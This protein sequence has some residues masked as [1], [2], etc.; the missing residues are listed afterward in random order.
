[1]FDG[2][3]KQQKVD[4][5]ANYLSYT[6]DTEPPVIYHRWCWLTSLG[7]CIGRKAYIDMGAIGRVFPNLYVQLLGAPAARKSTS[8]KMIKRLLSASGY[9][10]FAAD[11]TSKEK[12]LLDLE[13]VTEDGAEVGGRSSKVEY[14]TTT[15]ENLWGPDTEFSEPKE[16]FIVAD[17]FNDFA[18][19]GNLDFFTTL[20]SFW[21]F[22]N[23]DQ[24]YTHRLKNSKSV[25]IYQPTV[26][27]LSGNTPELFARCFPPEA[28][29]S[30]FLSRLLL[31]H[32]EPTNRR[33]TFPAKPPEEVTNSLTSFLSKMQNMPAVG[34]LGK[35]PDAYKILDDIY[36]SRDTGVDDLRFQA[37]NQ[38]RFTQLLKISI[39]IACAKFNTELSGE[40]VLQANTILTHAE[41]FMSRAMGEFGKNKNSDVANKIVAVIDTATKPI[42]PRQIWKEI[43]GVSALPS[44]KEMMEL[45][46][47][48][49]AAD[50]IQTVTVTGVSG[51]L[52]KKAI[53]REPKYVDWDFLTEEER[54]ML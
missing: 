7:A 1:M 2:T 25:S 52:P 46:H 5:F 30:G 39:I 14:D 37:Y 36:Q 9:D 17:E 38:R 15:A 13:G 29:G 26:S 19:P 42:L 3:S 54:N 49:I 53:R 28:I 24:S 48:L 43:G 4:V 40:D 27:L 35:S 33:I 34:E 41:M 23:P 50:K 47:G 16:V 8:I 32:G 31:I 12:F 10:S 18:G 22:D 51:F 21:D 6:K 45:L 11:K 20:G 44:Q